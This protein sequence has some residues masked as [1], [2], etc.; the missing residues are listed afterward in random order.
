MNAENDILLSV[1]RGD[2]GN[3]YELDYKNY[4]WF[5]TLR[6]KKIKR[7]DFES[8]ALKLN[9]I[10][11]NKKGTWQIIGNNPILDW[12]Y[13]LIFAN[14][15]LDLVPSGLKVYEIENILFEHF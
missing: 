5:D 4:T 1:V 7:K 8:L 10:E 6:P 14:K 9:H 12:N 3:T 15:N 11:L 13:R 2:E